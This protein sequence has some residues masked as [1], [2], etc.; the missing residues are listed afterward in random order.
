ML[1]ADLLKFGD[2]PVH[3]TTVGGLNFRGTIKS[4]SEFSLTLLS[5]FNET[6]LIPHS[7]IDSMRNDNEGG[8]R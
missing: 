7:S 1:R 6:V 8:R 2:N 3:V 4:V 5:Q